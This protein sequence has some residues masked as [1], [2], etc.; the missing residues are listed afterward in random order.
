MGTYILRRLL[1]LIPVMLIV[2]V[3]VFMLVH[4]TPGDPAAVILGQSATGEQ[5]QQLREELGLNDPFLVQFFNWFRNALR[6]DFGESLFLGMPVTE[7]LRERAQPTILLT[8]YALIFEILIGV[9]AGVIAA[10]KRNSLVDRVLMVM[11]IAGAAIPTFFLGIVLILVF[12]V[13]LKWVPAG[14]YVPIE[15]DPVQHFKGMILPAFTLGFSA[16]GLLA[17]LVRSS[18]LDVLRDDYIRTA[19][20]KGLKFR[21]VV[22]GHAL[23]NALIPAITVIGYSLGALLGGAVV[24]ETVFN[25]PGM[26]RLVVQSI[27]R[28]DYPLIQGAI[29]LIAG[30]YVLVNLL[31]DVLYVYIDPRIRYGS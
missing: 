30:I 18:M 12:A 23:R 14:G 13:R 22:T 10:I 3:V 9:P 20:A 21:K 27:S 1:M 15:E 28:R 25:I 24:T 4:L 8:T 26:G 11:S 16:A 5:I 6:L 31:V 17:R 7:A 2:G 29:M 19:M